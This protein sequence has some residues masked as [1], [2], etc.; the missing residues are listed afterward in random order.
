MIYPPKVAIGL[1]LLAR[2]QRSEDFSGSGIDPNDIDRKRL[3]SLQT[4]YVK[5]GSSSL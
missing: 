1:L 5:S 4:S 3:L 2:M